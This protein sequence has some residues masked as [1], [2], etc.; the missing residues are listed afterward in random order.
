MSHRERGNSGQPEAAAPG[1]I[2]QTGP[3]RQPLTAPVRSRLSADCQQ[4]DSQN[5]GNDHGLSHLEKPVPYS[6][7]SYILR[8]FHPCN[9]SSK[10]NGKRAA[11]TRLV[12]VSAAAF[13]Q[14]SDEQ[15]IRAIV[16]AGDEGKAI[17][18][19][20]IGGKLANESSAGAS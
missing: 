16:A 2:E 13:G 11:T 20:T 19:T 17:P 14:A 18:R 3:S 12:T 7:L 8:R 10:T 1:F 5:A 15:S 9:R 6:H 4:P